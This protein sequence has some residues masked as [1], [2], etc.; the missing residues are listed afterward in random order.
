MAKSQTHFYVKYISHTN[1]LL[2]FILL[3]TNIS[4]LQFSGV[5]KVTQTETKE[6]VPSLTQTQLVQPTTP[7]QPPQIPGL[8]GPAADATQMAQFSQTQM[9]GQNPLISLQQ[10]PSPLAPPPLPPSPFGSN[11]PVEQNPMMPQPGISPGNNA[12]MQEICNPCQL[13]F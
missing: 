7:G 3:S 9:Q 4:R 10:P 1:S 11:P 6:T 5:P 12:G 8:R 2:D 13:F